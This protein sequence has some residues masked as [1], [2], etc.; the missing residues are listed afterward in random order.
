MPKP[1]A[2]ERPIDTN[3]EPE[4]NG[5]D[6]DAAVG[7]ERI[8]CA[9]THT[10]IERARIQRRPALDFTSF[11]VSSLPRFEAIVTDLHR[12]ETAPSLPKTPGGGR[13]EEPSQGGFGRLHGHER[14]GRL[15]GAA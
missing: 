6:C 4:G 7:S 15:P 2:Y 9:N 14:R 1:A 11:T 12:V 3:C 10:G 5:A 13:R 8:H